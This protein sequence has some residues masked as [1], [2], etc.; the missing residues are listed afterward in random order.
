MYIGF[1]IHPQNFFDHIK[2]SHGNASGGDHNI[3][4]RQSFPQSSLHVVGAVDKIFNRSNKTPQR[5]HSLV[6][7]DATIFALVTIMIQ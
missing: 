2:F 4:T 1:E 5:Y 6:F 3:I 7:G